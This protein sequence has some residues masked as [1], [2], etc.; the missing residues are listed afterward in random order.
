MEQSNQEH[1]MSIP[2]KIIT[3]PYDYELLHHHVARQGKNIYGPGFEIND[4]DLPV[5]DSLLA[6]HLRDEATA[7][8]EGIDLEK[9]ILLM[10]PI[11]C[12]KTSLMN[13][14]RGLSPEA[15]RPL[16]RNCRDV[17]QEFSQQGYDVVNKYGKNSFFMYTSIPRVYCFDDLGL[18][19]MVTHWGNNCSVMAEILLS[20]YD[21]LISFKMITHATTNLNSEELEAVYGNRLRSRM[22]SMFNLIR[23]NAGTA[24]K[25][26]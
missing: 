23:F 22:R 21:M 18:E 9:G 3:P 4:V 15:Y 16:I 2:P 25:R 10:G 6:Y 13:I 7:A 26:K 20:R 5:I 17:A 19:S 11:G 14:M 12:G 8:G 24:D 1:S